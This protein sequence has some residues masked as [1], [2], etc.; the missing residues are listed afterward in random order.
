[1]VALTLTAGR[2]ANPSES[3]PLGIF[4]RMNLATMRSLSDDRILQI[5]E[6]GKELGT[7]KLGHQ[8]YAPKS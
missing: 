8:E 6:T 4:I 2:V 5:F 7:V 1:M 3:R